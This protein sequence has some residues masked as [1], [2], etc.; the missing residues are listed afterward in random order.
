MSLELPD[1]KVLHREQ[2]EA[3]LLLLAAT[4]HWHVK[5]SGCGVVRVSDHANGM[6]AGHELRELGWTARQDSVLA[7]ARALCP[8]CSEMF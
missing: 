4:L 8:G 1:L 3:N 7:P 2:R 5:C 6:P